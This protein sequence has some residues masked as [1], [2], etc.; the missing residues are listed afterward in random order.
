M[1][2]VHEKLE[3][4]GVETHLPLGRLAE[5]TRALISFQNIRLFRGF[6]SRV[7]GNGTLIFLLWSR[8]C[9]AWALV[10]RSD[11]Q[12]RPIL[13]Y[14]CS[15]HHLPVWE[16]NPSHRFSSFE[17]EQPVHI[18]GKVGRRDLSL[19]TLYADSTDEKLDVRLLRRKDMS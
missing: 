17:E 7:D 1:L 13:L 16:T 14:S 5:L 8:V 2:D 18:L 11:G 4:R 12:N 6:D 19:S 3:T 15:F 10:V 9:V